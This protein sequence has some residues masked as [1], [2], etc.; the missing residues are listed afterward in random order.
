M[1]WLYLQESVK[2][3]TK[4]QFIKVITYKCDPCEYTAKQKGSVDAH[5]RGHHRGENFTCDQ[6]D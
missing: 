4:Q 6:C 1:D 5:K 3:D 2:P